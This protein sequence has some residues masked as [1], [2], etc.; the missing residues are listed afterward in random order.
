MPLSTISV[1]LVG[2]P[3]WGLRIGQEDGELPIVSQVLPEGRAD[4]EGIR[5]GD[6]IDGVNGEDCAFAEQIHNKMRTAQGV[7]R[8]RLKRLD[9]SSNPPPTLAKLKII[10]ETEMFSTPESSAPPTPSSV[11][12]GVKLNSAAKPPLLNSYNGGMKGSAQD[13]KKFFEAVI[14]RQSQ[15]SPSLI[16][17]E[18]K[19]FYGSSLVVNT[20]SGPP[21]ESGTEISGYD[22][23]AAD[24][25]YSNG[26][27]RQTPSRN[28]E[29]S[30]D[31]W[32][33]RTSIDSYGSKTPTLYSEN[34]E[35]EIRAD[36]ATPLAIEIDKERGRPSQEF[37]W[38]TTMENSDQNDYSYRNNQMI[39]D[40][41]TD[42]GLAS[43]GSISVPH[44]PP[45][46]QVPP[47][48][49]GLQG[50]LGVQTPQVPLGF[51]GPQ[52]PQI[53]HELPEPKKWQIRVDDTTSKP[54]PVM[55][56]VSTGTAPGEVEIPRPQSYDRG[57]SPCSLNETVSDYGGM[58][59]N[60][61]TLKRQNSQIMM[62]PE[63]QHA[64]LLH[65]GLDPKPIRSSVSLMELSQPPAFP[66]TAA[67]SPDFHEN[68]ISNLSSAPFTNDKEKL[69]LYNNIENHSLKEPTKSSN[70][71]GELIELARRSF[72][73]DT[74]RQLVDVLWARS[75]EEEADDLSSNK[76]RL[77]RPHS[78]YEFSNTG[79]MNGYSTLPLPRSTVGRRRKTSTTSEIED[80]VNSEKSAWY[81]EMYKICHQKSPEEFERT[82]NLEAGEMANQRPITPQQ[83]RLEQQQQEQLLFEQQQRRARSVGR[84]DPVA[85]MEI[86]DHWSRQRAQFMREQNERP[87]KAMEVLQIACSPSLARQNQSSMKSI[88][89]GI[90]SGKGSLDKNPPGK[91]SL[92]KNPSGKSPSGNSYAITRSQTHH[93]HLPSYRFVHEDPRPI[94]SP[95]S[96]FRCG[97]DRRDYSW[98]EI[99]TLYEMMDKTELGNEIKKDKLGDRVKLRFI[100]N[101][102]E[103]TANDLQK[104]IDQLET[105]GKTRSKSSSDI[106]W[107][108]RNSNGKF[109][110]LTGILNGSP[111][112]LTKAV[113]DM[114]KMTME[115]I[116]QRQRAEKLSEELDD[117]KNR[118]HGYFPGAS[119][120]LQNNVQ[121]FDHLLYNNVGNNVG[122]NTEVTPSRCSTPARRGGSSGPIQTCTVLYK[123][124]SL[125]RGDVVRVHREVDSNWIEGER[126]G[127]VGI[128]P[129]SYVQMDEDPS[130]SRNKVRALYPFQAR[131]KNELSLRKGE[132]LRKRR[133]IDPNWLEGTNSKGQ[134]GI[135]PKC[136][137]QGLS[138]APENGEEDFSGVAPDRPK[139]P[140]ITTTN[141]S[142][143]MR[144]DKFKQIERPVLWSW[145][146]SSD[147]ALVCKPST[148]MGVIY[149]WNDKIQQELY[150]VVLGFVDSAMHDMKRTESRAL[151]KSRCRRFGRQMAAAFRAMDIDQSLSWEML[152]QTMLDS[153]TVS[154][155]TNATK[156]FLWQ[157][158][159]PSPS[160]KGDRS[161]Q[162]QQW[163]QRREN[164]GFSGPAKIVPK[165]S[166][167]YRAIYPYKPEHPDELELQEN[168]IVFVVEKCG[169]GWYIGTLLRTGQF[170]TFPG[171]YVEKH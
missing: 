57:Y 156:L 38:K 148:S 104:V 63:I 81:K 146:Y 85:D 56:S 64:I 118:R 68:D 51:P 23:V 22:S 9:K 150:E 59:S 82:V 27:E 47:V 67:R 168:D 103:E 151:L 28:T 130:T 39:H 86:L 65:P 30:D 14:A 11:A 127:H 121:R 93:F 20:P 131:N 33:R 99:E 109:N 143:E 50:L 123:E 13:K 140:K 78:V 95:N 141:S 21:S 125:N 152:G 145:S 112:Y 167:T 100:E 117:Q 128:F 120:A 84:Y 74:G 169:D 70:R 171:N 18:P 163:E 25:Y 16:K 69:L 149:S 162:I 108:L 116:L 41:S 7:L 45:I 132:I 72:N 75:D 15:P 32:Y 122:N 60:T 8:L 73:D 129:S 97:K 36:S 166:E 113:D 37:G 12:S 142:R 158:V 98:E 139:T 111:N 43:S 124:L 55:T 35:S 161:Y 5:P 105:F 71:L 79:K 133:E 96:C 53:P 58:Y 66:R 49:S 61:S 102:L 157:A 144:A 3:P 31:S 101:R 17:K 34:F 159:S 91:S 90:P 44:D 92:D 137:V 52:A 138:E 170:G 40:T 89:A 77:Q 76:S 48:P 29:T 83:A 1:S 164:F 160:K 46:T 135:F 19:K 94:I 62:S 115:E 80:S 110:Y 24:F 153:F 134:I 155:R 106:D 126:N 165:N 119:P 107:K 42:S 10:P 2:G 6:F 26:Y 54:A 154:F 4:K 136:Y 87:K 114:K 147:Q 88:A